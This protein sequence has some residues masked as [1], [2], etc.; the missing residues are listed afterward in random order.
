MVKNKMSRFYGSLCIWRV[1]VFSWEGR[2]TLPSSRLC[3]PIFAYF[4]PLY[5]CTT[6]VDKH[7][8]EGVILHI[9][10]NGV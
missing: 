10:T 8:W 4:R 7:P 2:K 5:E 6:T 9:I 3:L 1:H